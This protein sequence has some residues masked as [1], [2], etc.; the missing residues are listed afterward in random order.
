PRCCAASQG[1]AATGEWR[2]AESGVRPAPALTFTYTDTFPFSFAVT[3]NIAFAFVLP[4]TVAISERHA[5]SRQAPFE[6][7]LQRNRASRQRRLSSARYPGCG[8]P[9]L[10]IRGR[11]PRRGN[12]HQ[13]RKRGEELQPLQFL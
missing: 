7:E 2:A 3:I 9:G 5:D 12:L 6:R 1:E 11:K 10:R 13:E 8:G 4:V